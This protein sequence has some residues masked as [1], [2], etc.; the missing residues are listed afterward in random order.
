[1]I[2]AQYRGYEWE[3]YGAF[4]ERML[5]KHPGAQLLKHT[6]DPP[7]DIRFGTDQY[8]QVT[9]IS[10]EPN[11]SLPIFSSPDVHLAIRNYYEHRRVTQTYWQR[12]CN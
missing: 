10:P 2:S 11:R 4:C 6:G 3:K 1:M 12:P 7:V 8:I 5:N 9:A